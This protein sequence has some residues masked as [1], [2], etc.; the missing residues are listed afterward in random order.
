LGLQLFHID[1][2]FPVGVQQA[3]FLC[4]DCAELC[5]KG[6]QI[7]LE[8]VRLVHGF[9]LQPLNLFKDYLGVSYHF[10]EGIP[11]EFFKVIRFKH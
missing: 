9:L 11:Y 5:V 4:G 1:N 10:A 7:L 6:V 8:R 2:V 3:G